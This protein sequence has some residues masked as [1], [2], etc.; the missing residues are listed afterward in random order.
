MVVL[1]LFFDDLFNHPQ[2]SIKSVV[3]GTVV[4]AG[5]IE[6]NSVWVAKPI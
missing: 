6:Q 4:N 2:A 1:D 5:E 3:P